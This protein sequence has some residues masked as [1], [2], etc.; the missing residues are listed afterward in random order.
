MPQEAH[1]TSSLT[2]LHAS[3]SQASKTTTPSAG[4][5]SASTNGTH[6]PLDGT[7]TSTDTDT[8]AANA[9][10]VEAWEAAHNI[11]KA[12]NIGSLLMDSQTPDAQAASSSSGGDKPPEDSTGG[13]AAPNPPPHMPPVIAQDVNPLISL[14]RHPATS[15]SDPSSSTSLLALPTSQGVVS[16]SVASGSGSISSPAHLAAP[17]SAAPL[18]T[19]GLSMPLHELKNPDQLRP[20]EELRKCLATLAAQLADI[21]GAGTVGGAEDA[22]VVGSIGLA[23]HAPANGVQIDVI[24]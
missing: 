6:P 24:S 16:A 23:G 14:F 9:A 19:M 21:A 1:A 10:A 8:A 11:L 4:V 12:L 7:S 22:G 13:P 5:V 2:N 15:S 20:R 17:M 3:A 18:P